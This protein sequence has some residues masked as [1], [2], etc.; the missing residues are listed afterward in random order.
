MIRNVLKSDASIIADIYNYYVANSTA[1]FEEEAVDEAEFVKRIESVTVDYTLPWIVYE[2]EGR[3]VAYAY[4]K[5]FH[6]RSAYRY[7]LETSIYINHL[8]CG[9]GI[10]RELYSALIAKLQNKNVH[11]LIGLLAHP[12]EGSENLHRKLGFTISGHLKEAGFKFGKWVDITYWQLF[13]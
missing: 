8:V 9:K 1:T 3:V 10:G 5:P 13:L 2:D 4:S 6:P 12:N 7:T 11:S